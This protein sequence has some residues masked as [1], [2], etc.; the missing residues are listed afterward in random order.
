[1][2]YPLILVIIWKIILISVFV[3]KIACMHF[4]IVL[5]SKENRVVVFFLH[6]FDTFLY[7]DI[8]DIILM[9]GTS[10]ESFTVT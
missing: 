10:G 7:E 4:I 1:M 9:L 5:T 6:Y 8:T 3:Q 2:T